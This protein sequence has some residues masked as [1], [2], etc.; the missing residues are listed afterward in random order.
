MQVADKNIAV[1]PQLCAECDDCFR[2]ECQLCKPCHSDEMKLI[3][4]QSY[5]EHRNKMDF[6]RI[7]PPAI[8]SNNF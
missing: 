1:L 2:V 3:L 8:V 7:F 5:L 6:R 4:S